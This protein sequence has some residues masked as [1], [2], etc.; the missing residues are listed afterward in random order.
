MLYPTV[1]NA[2]TWLGLFVN[3]IAVGAGIGFGWFTMSCII[4]KLC[5]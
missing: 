1:L 2:M 3:G 4:S 5:R